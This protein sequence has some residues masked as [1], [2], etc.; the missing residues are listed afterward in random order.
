MYVCIVSVVFS[1]FIF[2]DRLQCRIANCVYPPTERTHPHT[3]EK[4]RTKGFVSSA[5]P[6]RSHTQCFHGDYTLCMWFFRVEHVGIKDTIPL[7]FT[8]NYVS[9]SIQNCFYV[10]VHMCLPSYIYNILFKFC[11]FWTLL[12]ILFYFLT[13]MI[14][15]W[16]KW[17]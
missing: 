10:C 14:T 12:L 3:A 16:P 7:V 5:S 9:K 17:G 2:Y 8:D 1:L 13:R 6:E 4:M 11:F 15:I